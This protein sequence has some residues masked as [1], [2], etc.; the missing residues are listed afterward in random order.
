MRARANPPR[1]PRE[2]GIGGGLVQL[3]LDVYEV[4]LFLHE[5]DRSGTLIAFRWLDASGDLGLSRPENGFWWS[6]G[7]RDQ[8]PALTGSGITLERQEDRL[9]VTLLGYDAG[10][11]IW[12]FGSTTL[13]GSV[14]RVHLM[15]MV[16]G[17]GSFDG[18]PT[19]PIAEP[20]PVIHLQ[21]EAPA[22]AKAWLERPQPGSEHAIELQALELLRLAFAPGRTGTAWRGR[23]ILLR[24]GGDL[25]RVIALTS[26]STVDADSFRL[27][28]D[29]A[30]TTLDCRLTDTS[31]H[32]MPGSCSLAE[33]GAVLATFN[34]VGL[35]RMV[36]QD[37]NGE[38]IEFLR[39]PD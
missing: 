28:D 17:S 25:A 20:G 21:F 18:L 15:R 37:A 31:G 30:F 22:R 36:G 11:P 10:N 3:P 14:A 32:A 6:L 26:G 27:G 38:A 7:T 1:P 19:A 12:Y 39:V 16:G 9:A 13:R 23:W 4:R 35:D 2:S 34:R 24:T 33:A 5:A 29:A 8:V